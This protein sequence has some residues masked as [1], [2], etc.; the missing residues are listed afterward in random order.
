MLRL[1]VA[2]PNPLLKQQSVHISA[3]TEH[4]RLGSAANAAVPSHPK[5][6]HTMVSRDGEEA[7]AAGKCV[8]LQKVPGRASS[9]S[10]KPSSG[11][12]LKQLHAW[13]WEREAGLLFA[14][15]HWCS[16]WGADFRDCL[17]RLFGRSIGSW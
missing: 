9:A 8:P 3:C 10:S 12:L 17:F 7:G 15:A 2:F 6:R 4:Q 14:A 5:L 16:C 1:S 11:F 13:K